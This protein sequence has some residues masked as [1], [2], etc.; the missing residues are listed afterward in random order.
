[1]SI[2]Q[3][4]ATGFAPHVAADATAASRPASVEAA[5]AGTV[6]VELPAKA[7]QATAAVPDQEQVKQAV[8]H[9]NKI[10]QS[11]T[12][13]VEFSVDE[14]TGIN[15]VKVMDKETNEVIRQMPSEE[16][17]ALDRSLDK[18]KGLIIRQK[19]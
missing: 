3:V 10:V 9:L 14:S 18:L 19:A 15:V 5:R 8:E 1:M 4:G 7:V 6:S 16:I 12:S 13:D 17:L 2:S 11:M